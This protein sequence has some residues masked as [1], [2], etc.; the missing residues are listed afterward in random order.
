MAKL[1]RKRKKKIKRIVLLVIAT[2]ILGALIFLSPKIIKV[3]KLYRDAKAYAATSTTSTFKD[4]KTTI[5]YDANGN[6]LCTM[7]NDRDMY[8]VSFDQIPKT[9]QNAFIVMEDRD[10]YNHGGIDYKAIIRAIIVN[11]KSNEIEQGAST[12][13]QQLAR[14]IFL[15]MDV[16]WERKIEEMFLAQELEKMYS[17]DQILEFYLNNI[18]FGNGYYGVEAAARGYFN[19]SVSELTLSQQAFIAGIPNNPSRNDPFTQMEHAMNRRNLILN[20]M[21][22]NDY[23][24]SMNYYTAL[25]EEIVLDQPVVTKNNSVETYARYCATESM[26]SASGFVFMNNF[27][28]DEEYEAYMDAYYDSYTKN[29]SKLLSGGYTIYTSIDMNLQNKLQ[30]AI[31]D[32][33]KSRTEQSSE[34]VYELQ[35]AGVCVD[36]ATGNVVAIVGARSQ[37]LSGYTLNRAYQS[38]RQPGSSI[39]P[40]IVYTPFLQKG[41]TPDTKVDDFPIEGGPKNADGTYSGTITLREAVKWS[42]NTVAWNIYQD[43]TPKVGCSFLI[44]MGFHKAWV[45]KDYNALS[46]GGFTYGVSPVEMAGAYATIANEGAYRKP[47]CIQR[48]I[49]AAGKT[50]VDETIRGT[51]KI[52]DINSCRMMTD[53]MKT[54]MESGTGVRAQVDNAIVAGKTG[55]TND[56]KDF[57]FCGFSRYYTTAVWVG[58][59]IPKTEANGSSYSGSI[60][61]DYMTAAHE[62]LSKKDFEPYKEA[63]KEQETQTPTKAEQETTTAVPE[64]ETPTPSVTAT[65]TTAG[66]QQ[67]TTG[68]NGNSGNNGNMTQPATPAPTYPQG[69]WDAGIRTDVDPDADATIQ[70]GDW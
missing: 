47:T 14:N 4:A 43:L 23:I 38:Y 20:E 2:I 37:E 67:S 34:G 55:T 12:I 46:L 51:V 49:N 54:V 62:N 9:L 1:S 58:D 60:W 39:K 10:F 17:K 63:I 15:T 24:N 32:N 27:N 33:L 52:Y 19:K 42:R 70:G 61:K 5:I 3:M 7:K 30:Q 57:W 48:I 6:Q 69:E 8:Y 16:T 25:G 68:N 65:P 45:D 66:N 11:Q 41:N 53:M 36:N 40:L 18:Y 35:S 44:N 56:D 13:T 31:D 22:G 28:S 29:E 21:Y 26:M 64:E 50:V 59:D